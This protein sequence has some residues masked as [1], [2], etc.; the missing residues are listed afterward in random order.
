MTFTPHFAKPVD[1]VGELSSWS[2]GETTGDELSEHPNSTNAT[3]AISSKTT[4]RAFMIMSFQ[5]L[6]GVR[7]GP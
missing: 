2:V 6:V 5:I 3:L 1:V 4:E 7:L